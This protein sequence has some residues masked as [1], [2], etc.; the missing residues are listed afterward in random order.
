MMVSVKRM[1]KKI[2]NNNKILLMIQE[3]IKQGKMNNLT[4]YIYLAVVSG[5]VFQLKRVELDDGQSLYCLWV[6]RDQSLPG[7]GSRSY[8]SLTMASS[9]NSTLDGITRLDQS[10]II[11]DSSAV[12]LGTV[13]LKRFDSNF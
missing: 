11:N 4:I 13:R 2:K 9:F 10:S 12:S 5:V 7:E 3:Y 8:A 1:F 6:S